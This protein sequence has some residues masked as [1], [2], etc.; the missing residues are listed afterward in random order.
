M[1]CLIVL[2]RELFPR[3]AL[4]S[5]RGTPKTM[6]SLTDYD[7]DVVSHVCSELEECRRAADLAGI[8]R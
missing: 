2:I 5:V 1:K 6:T 3:L 4:R 8:P 7:S